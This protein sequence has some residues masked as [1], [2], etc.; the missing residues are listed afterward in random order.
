MYIM[1]FDFI[2]SCCQIVFPLRDSIDSSSWIFSCLPHILDFLNSSYNLKCASVCMVVCRWL[3][4]FPFFPMDTRN[5]ELDADPLILYCH[6]LYFPQLLSQT[7][8]LLENISCQ[9]WPYIL[10]TQ[11]IILSGLMKPSIMTYL[12]LFSE[13]VKSAAN[14]G[15]KGPFTCILVSLCRQLDL[16]STVYWSL[17]LN[18]ELCAKWFF[19]FH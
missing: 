6:Y 5:A 9:L 15:F 14:S 17:C 13:V 19:F 12:R 10:F 11:F 18:Q 3:I 4:S 8:S 7:N 1:N 2:K 16:K